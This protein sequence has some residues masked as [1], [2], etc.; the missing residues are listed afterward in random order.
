MDAAGKGGAIRRI[1]AAIDARIYDVIPIAAPSDEGA[2]ATV[3]WRFWR[4]VPRDG[5]FAI[6]DR[7]WYGRVL[8]ER[9]E[10]FARRTAGV[11]RTTRSTTSSNSSRWRA[12]PSPSSGCSSRP[13]S[14]CVASKSA[15]ARSGRSS[16]SHPTTGANRDK[17]AAYQL[18]ASEMIERTSTTLAPW[19][20]VEAE[21]KHF[22]RVKIMERVIELLEQSL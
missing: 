22:G 15:R 21:D 19:T 10:G 13:R 3:L 18:A 7:S 11:A 17:W 1:T 6:F 2:R 9:V 20:I 8:V 16:R 4:H 5:K 12:A 14:S